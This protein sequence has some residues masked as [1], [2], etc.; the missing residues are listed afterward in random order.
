M[1]EDT[2]CLLN[3]DEIL[4][5]LTDSGLLVPDETTGKRLMVL[6]A[7]NDELERRAA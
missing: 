1:I 2:E 3:A 6:V 5:V 4:G 7:A